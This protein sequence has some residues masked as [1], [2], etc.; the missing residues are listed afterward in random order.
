MAMAGTDGQF[1]E[2]LR[3]E[4]REFRLLESRHQQLDEELNQLVRHHVLTPD[5]E[6]KKKVLQKEKLVTKDR[7]ARLIH[8]SHQASL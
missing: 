8:D 2:R 3:R 5:E 6:V 7:M 4:N 1:I